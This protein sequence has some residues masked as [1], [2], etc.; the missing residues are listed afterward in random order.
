MTE[1]DTFDIL[2]R[3]PASDAWLL[4]TE[5]MR[6]ILDRENLEIVT[7]SNPEVEKYMNSL[8]WNNGQELYTQYQKFIGQESKK[9]KFD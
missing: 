8:G 6:K 3:Y 7:T 9:Y 1:D 2:R 4:V 5:Y